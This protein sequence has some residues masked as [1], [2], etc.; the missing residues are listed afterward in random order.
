MN[1]KVISMV[2]A[3][4]MLLSMSSGMAEN[5]FANPGT[6]SATAMG[7]NGEVTVTATFSDSAITGIEVTHEETPTLGDTAI[8]Q[9]TAVVLKNQTLDVDAISGATLSSGA[10]MEALEDC[11]EQAGGDVGALKAVPV[12]NAAA[13]TEYDVTEA[14]IIIVGAGGAG[15]TAAKT[16]ADAGASVILIEKSGVVGGNSLCSQ[17]GINA[18]ASKVQETL[19]MEYATED[20]LKEAQMQWGGRE[21]LVNAYV[22]NS[23]KAVDWFA[24]NLGIDFSGKTGD[25]VDPADPL[26]SVG[27]DHPSGSELFMVRAD[28]DGYT[29]NTLVKALNTAIVGAGVKLY[30]NTEATELIT[31]ENGAVIGVKAKA[32]DGSEVTF[33]GKAVLLATGG[34]GQNHEMVVAYRPDLKNAITD[35]MAPTTGDGVMMAEAVGAKTVDMAEMQLFPHVPVGDTW[36]SPMGMPGGF[37]TTGLFL[38]QDAQ[39]YTTEGFDSSIEGTLAQEHAF[40]I[41]GESDLNDDLKRLEARGLV[42][43]G[44]TAEELAAQLGLDGAALAETIEKWNADCDAGADSQFERLPFTLKKVEGKLYGYAF[45]VGAHY[46]MGGVLI[47]EKTQVLDQEENVIPGLYAAGEVT[48]GFHGSKRVDGS[49]TGDAFVFGYLA[50]NE[51]AAEIAGN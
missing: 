21:N 20:L 22:E 1:K 2:L 37:M 23:G 31:D 29:S 9:L 46:M 47:N 26:A 51:I 28:A 33:S 16:A 25:Q 24:E 15:L 43:S 12:E 36:L 38:N 5:S 27:E 49:G 44:D 41:F 32:A 17:M 11:V 39:R 45:G 42:K 13:Q 7:R 8:E 10:F 19:G 18:A 34:F 40:V 6:Y 35:E 50:G 30:V 3:G 14:D 4:S 48:G